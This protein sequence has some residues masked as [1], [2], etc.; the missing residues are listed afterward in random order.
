[1]AK[2]SFKRVISSFA[3]FSSRS[4]CRAKLSDTTMAK[5]FFEVLIISALVLGVGFIGMNGCLGSCFILFVCR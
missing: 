5:V 2:I 3:L 4:S 1:M